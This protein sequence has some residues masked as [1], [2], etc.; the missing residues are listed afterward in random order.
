MLTVSCDVD[1]VLRNFKDEV[2]LKWFNHF[3]SVPQIGRDEWS[4]IYIW[5]HLHGMTREEVD[6]LVFKVW[7]QEI[8]Q[9]ARPY[10]GAIPMLSGLKDLGCKIILATAQRTRETQ[11]GTVNWV[12]EWFVPH[13]KLVFATN[14]TAIKANI[15]IDDRFETIKDLE[16]L[17]P[18]A[19][20]LLVN[21]PWN[22]AWRLDLGSDSGYKVVH[23]PK[24]ISEL[25]EIFLLE[26]KYTRILETVD[27]DER[28]ERILKLRNLKR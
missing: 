18:D 7:G 21:R 19:L 6:H 1:G 17:Y 11:I 15:Y 14:K 26:G 16:R 27:D 13:D 10:S 5:G 22:R 23:Y 4:F 20:N 25:V 3:G 24:Q 9:D 2:T 8:M 12:R 28:A